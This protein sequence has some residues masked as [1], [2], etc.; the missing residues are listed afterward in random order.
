MFVLYYEQDRPAE[1]E[2]AEPWDRCSE[3]TTAM[4]KFNAD[5]SVADMRFVRYLRS[6][7]NGVRVNSRG[8]IFVA[9]NFM[10]VGVAYPPDIAA[11]MGVNPL[12]RPYPARLDDAS[13]DQLLR[14]T[15][16]LFKFGPAG[17]RI[18]GLPEDASIPASV[19]NPLD[20]YRPVP[21]NQWF[22]H[23]L[24]RLRVTGAE[25]QFHGISPI[26]AE[27]QGVTHVERC[28]CRSGRFDIDPFDRVFVPDIFRHRFTVLDSA[29]NLI[30]RFGHYGNRDDRGLGFSHATSI[31]ADSDYAFVGD[32]GNRRLVRVVFTYAAEAEAAFDVRT[33]GR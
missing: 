7:A 5:G 32:E 33:R 16:S 1:T 24:H 15:G 17:G 13:F 2:P 31:A 20:L 4:A 9:D 27:Y 11:V 19:K 21:E 30:C 22:L 8:E 23:N 18:T 25:W 3:F 26:P 10:P 14:W 28:V 29:G 12:Q 6:G